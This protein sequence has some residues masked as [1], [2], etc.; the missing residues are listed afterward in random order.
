MAD[1]RRR[2]DVPAARL[3]RTTLARALIWGA[4]V[5]A[6]PLAPFPFAWALVTWLVLRARAAWLDVARGLEAGRPGSVTLSADGLEL[7][8]DGARRVLRPGDVVEGWTEPLTAGEGAAVVIVT[9][10]RE[11]IALRLDDDDARLV[12]QAAGVGLDQQALRVPLATLATQAGQGAVF[13]LLAPF[14]LLAFSLTPVTLLAAGLATGATGLA[15]FGG[16]MLLLVGLAAAAF[17]RSVV[18][19][20]AVVGVDGV[21]IRYPGRKRFHRYGA[22]ESV[23]TRAAGATIAVGGERIQLSTL[24]FTGRDDGRGAALAARL[25]EAWTASRAAEG[26]EAH[27]EKLGLLDRR[28]RPLA[29]WRDDLGKLALGAATYRAVRFDAEELARV[30]ED[31]AAPTE[32]RVGAALAL[33]AAPR[34]D[35]RIA[36]GATANE[37]VRRALD[38]ALEG[39]L[40]EA[41]L[42]A[43]LAEDTSSRRQEGDEPPARE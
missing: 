18:P 13:H 41:E 23:G 2:I 10:D 6:T 35:L 17:V 29:T 42:E 33:S 7:E 4:I 34:T 27:G 38:A 12:L 24:S 1:P 30:V 3:R 26:L 32:R 22:I 40:E 20:L 31:P 5:L 21:Q 43:A 14:L 25:R 19:G 11:R 16:V 8:V 39:D 37:S 36:T 15:V 9:R 28:G